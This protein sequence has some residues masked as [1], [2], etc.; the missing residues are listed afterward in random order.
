MK[1]SQLSGYLNAT[2][3]QKKNATGCSFQVFTLQ[4]VTTIDLFEMKWKDNS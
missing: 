2:N 4:S 3:K 1:C